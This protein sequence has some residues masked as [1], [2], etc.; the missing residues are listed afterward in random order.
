MLKMSYRDE[1]PPPDDSNL[2]PA[3]RLDFDN[4]LALRPPLKPDQV[5]VWAEELRNARSVDDLL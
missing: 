3:E 5:E 2:S 1:P 4:V